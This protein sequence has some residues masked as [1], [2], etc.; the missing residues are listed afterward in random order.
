MDS[1]HT[2]EPTSRIKE[3]TKNKR[4]FLHGAGMVKYSLQRTVNDHTCYLIR[5][6]TKFKMDGEI[7]ELW[8]ARKCERLYELLHST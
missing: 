2:S 3:K 5:V 7:F 1:G 4:I 6:R 8:S